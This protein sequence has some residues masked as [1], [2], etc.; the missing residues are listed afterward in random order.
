[1]S[2]EVPAWR[3]HAKPS[4]SRHVSSRKHV[5]SGGSA[6]SLDVLLREWDKG[7]KEVSARPPPMETHSAPR[8]SV[9]VSVCVDVHVC[10]CVCV[11]VCV[12]V[13]VCVCVCVSVC[14][15][16]CVCVRVCA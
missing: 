7:K 8:V 4:T 5:L 9:S 3:A 11:C 1:M 13:R 2:K 10:L 15:C 12:R 16:L 14:V 6:S